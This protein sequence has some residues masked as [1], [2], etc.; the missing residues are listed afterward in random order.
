MSSSNDTQQ[1]DN[2]IPKLGI[3]R[4]SKGQFEKGHSG[5][6]NAAI[7]KK[8]QTVK[9]FLASFCEEKM[10]EIPALYEQLTVKDKIN[11][12]FKIIQMNSPQDGNGGP[13]S[14]QPITITFQPAQKRE[15]PHG[16]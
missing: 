12:L 13:A 6:I 11:M 7:H 10:H 14:D 4:N 1:P 2:E 16:N 5:N 15:N 9:D 8:T 3:V